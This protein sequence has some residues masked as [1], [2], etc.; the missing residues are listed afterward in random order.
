[1]TD[2]PYLR[3]HV[4]FSPA[5]RRAFLAANKFHYRIRRNADGSYKL[6]DQSG[7]PFLYNATL[8]QIE[9]FLRPPTTGGKHDPQS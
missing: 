8:T 7:M 6:T 4:K 1:M 5:E 9:D 3:N 2:E